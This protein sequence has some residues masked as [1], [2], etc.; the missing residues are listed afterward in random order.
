MGATMQALQDRFLFGNQN[1]DL[2]IGNPCSIVNHIVTIKSSKLHIVEDDK[3]ILVHKNSHMV[4]KS[5]RNRVCVILELNVES[6]I[7]DHIASC[8]HRLLMHP[9]D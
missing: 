9:C 7:D 6:T 2:K 5:N 3:K 8:R 4:G 1:F